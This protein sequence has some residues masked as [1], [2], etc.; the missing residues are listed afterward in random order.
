MRKPA[1][2]K[3]LTQKQYELLESFGLG[4][5]IISEMSEYQ[6]EQLRKAAHGAVMVIPFKDVAGME[7]LAHNPEVIRR[8]EDTNA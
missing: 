2:K 8:T 5:I 1:R 4:R 6:I 7:Y 3:H